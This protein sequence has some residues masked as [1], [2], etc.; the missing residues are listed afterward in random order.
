MHWLNQLARR[1]RLY[2]DL[3]EEI[4]EH[5]QEKTN[6]LIDEGM[7][8]EEAS[9]AAK[10]EFGNA[11]LI[12]ERGRET[13]RWTQFEDFLTDVRYGLRAFRKNPAFAGVAVL[14]LALAIG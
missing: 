3:S 14:T 11:T 1:Q 12:E 6:E 13:W 2:D 4:Q 9:A 10:R 5:L 8:P 7:S